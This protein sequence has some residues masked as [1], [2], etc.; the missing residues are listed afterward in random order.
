MKN[1]LILIAATLAVALCIH[2]KDRLIVMPDMTYSSSPAVVKGV[3]KG[4][5][6]TNKEAV[7][8]KYLPFGGNAYETIN[9]TISTTSPTKPSNATFEVEVPLLHTDR[10]QMSFRDKTYTLVLA[11]GEETEVTIDM[12]LLYK[13][14]A[15]KPAVTFKGGS[16]ADFNDDFVRY[17]G[18][19][20]SSAPFKQF[21]GEGATALVQDNAPEQ[22]KQKV[23]QAYQNALKTLN[24]DKRLCGAFKQYVYATYQYQVLQCLYS[25]TP[26]KRSVMGDNQSVTLPDDYYA[27]VKEW[28]PFENEA[29]IYAFNA[30]GLN[31]VATSFGTATI[32]EPFAT[33][34]S[35]EQLKTAAASLA[36]V[37]NGV[38]L[39]AEQ[40]ADLQAKCPVLKDVVLKENEALARR[41][42]ENRRNP[43]AFE[44]Q[45]S[46]DLTGTDIF[47]AIIAPYR[48][49]P[50]LVDFWAT[51]CGPCKAAMKTIL[52]VKEELKGKVTFVYVSAPTSPREAWEAQMLDI[53]GE[54]FYV[55]A[56]QWSAL[57]GQFESQGIPTYVVVDK[58][59]N[60]VNKHIGYP[61]NDV[62]KEELTK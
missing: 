14:D 46:A 6:T 36:L 37:R 10:V 3:I 52:P 57:L 51:W 18:V 40:T 31:T 26:R 54:H 30:A 16:L 43:Q 47:Q 60:I 44:R 7:L 38:T 4:Y 20:D 39:S 49:K 59:G 8:M 27:E 22:Y 62:I 55:T 53:H 29:M 28:K 58:D 21:Q 56:D 23:L 11:P 2:A 35:Y 5:T 19:Y 13:A 1:R 32:K 50:V 17:V 34:R 41:I 42:E 24:A 33:P 15:K 45:I 12:T 25:Y 9:A 61:G 48:G